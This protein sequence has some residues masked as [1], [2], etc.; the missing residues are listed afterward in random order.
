MIIRLDKGCVESTK[1]WYNE[2]S[3]TLLAL[4]Y[5]RNP[6]DQCVS[7]KALLL[8]NILCACMSTTG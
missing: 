1:L 3:G 5:K 6:V 4:G 7:I 8:S 2:L